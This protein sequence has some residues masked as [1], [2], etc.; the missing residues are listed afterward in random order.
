MIDAVRD[1]Y[2]MPDLLA[3]RAVIANALY[4]KAGCPDVSG[5]SEPFLDVKSG[6]EYYDAIVWAYNSGL[7]KGTSSRVFSPDLSVNRSSLAA[8]LWAYA[9]SPSAGSAVSFRDAVLIKSANRHAAEWAVQSGVM[10]AAGTGYFNPGLLV[11]RA[12]LAAAV[13]MLP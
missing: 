4:V 12:E 8:I 2:F 1:K 13:Y 9:G 3:S 7:M 11:T 10:G 6:D 5:M